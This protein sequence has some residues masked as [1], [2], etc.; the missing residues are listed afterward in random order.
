MAHKQLGS[1]EIK[2]YSQNMSDI[3]WVVW[4]PPTPFVSNCQQL[5]YAQSPFFS[6]RQN[7]AQPPFPDPFSVMSAF[8]CQPIPFFSSYQR[9]SDPH[10]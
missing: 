8:S 6:D 7:L 4:N 1:F 9:W 10:W 5:D 3:V 2:E